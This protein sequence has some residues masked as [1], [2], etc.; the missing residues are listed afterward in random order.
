M[1]GPQVRRSRRH[2]KSRE[3]SG[4]FRRHV[5]ARS[6]RADHGHWAS[7]VVAAYGV[8]AAGADFE[9]VAHSDAGSQYTGLTTLRCSTTMSCSRRS[10][11]SETRWTTRSPKLSW[12][13]TNRADRRP[14]VALPRAARARDRDYVGWLTTSGCTRRSATS[15]QSSSSNATRSPSPLPADGLRTA[16]FSTFSVDLA[17]NSPSRRSTPPSLGA[18]PLG[19]RHARPRDPDRDRRPLRPA[20]TEIFADNS[21]IHDQATKEPT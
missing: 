12:T 8:R 18:L 14:C 6:R 3:A 7:S 5:A 21:N 2:E 4:R 9:L 13:L 15:R 10:A 20:F 19:P 17:G 16:C 1:R 11:L